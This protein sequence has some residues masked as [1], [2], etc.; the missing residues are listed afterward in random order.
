M[1]TADPLIAI[2]DDDASLRTALVGLVRSLGYR[3]SG[4]GSA[5]EFLAADHAAQSACIVTDIQMPG[6]SGIELKL[7]LTQDGNAAPV[8]MITARTEQG[9]RDRAFASGAVCVLQKPFAAEA[10]IACLE[11]ALAA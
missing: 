10:L 1:D 8:I 2:I 5:E 4:F 9:L 3:A 11:K 7:R 6:L